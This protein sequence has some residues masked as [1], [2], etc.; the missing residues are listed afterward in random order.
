M[1]KKNRK[2]IAYRKAAGFTQNDM[3]LFLDINQTTYSKKENGKADFTEKEMATAYEKLFIV[4]A[5]TYPDLKITD[6][7][8]GS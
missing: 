8:F 4:L 5:T 7:F 6:I 3:A 1:G 2:L